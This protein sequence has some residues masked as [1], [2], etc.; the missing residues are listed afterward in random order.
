MD[1]L[2][3][4]VPHSEFGATQRKKIRK[5]PEKHNLAEISAA[6]EPNPDRSGL[7]VHLT[8]V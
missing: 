4:V 2:G 7:V 6:D 8:V 3:K 1:C 5:F